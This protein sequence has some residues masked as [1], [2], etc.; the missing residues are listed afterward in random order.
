MHNT[1]EIRTKRVNTVLQ[2]SR[3]PRRAPFDTEPHRY[4]SDS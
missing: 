2:Q 3:R 4:E 1:L